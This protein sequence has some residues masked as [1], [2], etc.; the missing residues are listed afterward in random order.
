MSVGAYITDATWQSNYGSTAPA[1]GPTTCTRSAR[2]ARARTA[3]SSRTII[4]PGAAVSTTPLWQPG[5]PVAGTYTLPPGYSMLNGT[6]MASPQA[7]GA[8]AL[9]VSAAE[10]A[11]VQHQPAQ[12]RQALNSSARFLHRYGA[13]EQGNGLIDVGAAWALLDQRTSRRSTS[14]RRSRSTRCSISSS[15]R[16]ASA[17]ASTTARAWTPGQPYTREYTFTRTSGGGGTTTYNLS[18]VGND[19]HVQL[20]AA[21][22]ALPKNQPRRR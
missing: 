6:S 1:P 18:W 10:Q 21:S 13:Y 12:L 9:L 15:P 2:A 3:A 8:A 19:G 16:R 4:A 22:I 20:S 7:A 11:G 17:S 5:G 14:R